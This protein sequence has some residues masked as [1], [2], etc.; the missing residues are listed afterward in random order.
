ML[1]SC[2]FKVPVYT[3]AQTLG[4]ALA[5]YIGRHIYGIKPDLMT[6]R[7][8]QSCASAFWVELIATFMIMFLAASLTH[9]AQ[10]VRKKNSVLFL[11]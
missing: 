8:L 1:F 5:T 3:L 10:A 11:P 6:T 4:S 7:P 9:Q 2:N